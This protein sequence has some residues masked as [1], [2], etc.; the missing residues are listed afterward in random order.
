MIFSSSSVVYPCLIPRMNIAATVAI[1]R[2]TNGSPRKARR[3]STD[4][5][6][7]ITPATDLKMISTRGIKMIPTM[8]P[9]AG[10][11]DSSISSWFAT[12]SGTGT[13]YF[14]PQMEP[15]TGPETII[16]ATP[17]AIPTKI[18]HPRSTLS[19]VATR[20]GPGVGGINA[21]PTA[22]P[23]RSGIA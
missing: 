10:S 23:A 16:A 1:R 7:G 17:Q 18:T 15:H 2:A 14:L 12:W 5:S 8:V 20:T 22:K 11:L 6:P 9:K 13:K 4:A 3:G 19:M 21:C